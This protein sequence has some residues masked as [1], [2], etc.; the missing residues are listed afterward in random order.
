MDIRPIKTDEDYRAALAEI[1]QLFDA[2]P[3][4]PEG[5]R[6]DVLATL[7]EAYEQRLFAIPAPDPVEAIRY[8]MESRGLSRQDLEAALGSR[9]RVSEILNHKRPLSLTMIRNLHN[10]FGIPAESLIQPCRL[11]A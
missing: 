7:V 6:L 4:T 10:R 2:Q 3:D 8:H 5:D 9:A 11:A 1:E